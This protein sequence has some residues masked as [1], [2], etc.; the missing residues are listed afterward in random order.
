MNKPDE[1]K[2]TVRFPLKD[3]EKLRAMAVADNR[4]LNAEIV[5]AV[6]AFTVRDRKKGKDAEK[7]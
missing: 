6:Q 5:Q 7:L 3:S 1:I 2:I 4:S